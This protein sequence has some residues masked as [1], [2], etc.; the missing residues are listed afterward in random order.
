M[1]DLAGEKI[2]VCNSKILF[3]SLQVG[4]TPVLTPLTGIAVLLG[5]SESFLCFDI[6]GIIFE[7]YF[8]IVF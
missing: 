5:F 7:Q 1:P 6:Q 3:L 2:Q 8:N 4:V